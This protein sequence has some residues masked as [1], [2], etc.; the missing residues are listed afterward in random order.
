MKD[1]KDMLQP[2]VS[3]V[4]IIPVMQGGGPV[5]ISDS[6]LPYSLPTLSLRHAAI[7]PG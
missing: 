4:S 7:F 1:L 3:E 2:T 5:K 6:E